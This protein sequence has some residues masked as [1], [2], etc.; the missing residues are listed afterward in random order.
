MKI[1]VMR[2]DLRDFDLTQ[3]LQVVG[4][5]RQYMCV[6]VREQSSVLGSIFVKAG[7]VLKVDAPGAQGREALFDLIAHSEGQF[8]VFRM[9]TPDILPEPIGALHGLLIEARNDNAK[10]APSQSQTHVSVPPDAGIPRSSTDS[11]PSNSRASSTNH[12]SHASAG[13]QGS[14]ASSMPSLF[15]LSRSPG[16][17]LAGKVISVAS[18]K[19]GCGKTTL[20]LNIALSLARQGRSVVLV[21]A[22]I[23]GDILSAIDA[24][25]RAQAGAFETL[26]GIAELDDALLNTVLPHFRILPAVGNTL[27]NASA[28]N[29]DHSSAWSALLRDLSAQAEIVVV[30]TPA[31]MFGVT[32]QVL[33][34]SS[35]VLGVLQA[36][37]L[38]N[39][40]FA[41]F[42]E[43]VD[44]IP[45][46]RRPTIV[47]I[48]I[49]MLQTSHSASLSVFQDACTALP[50]TL[51]FDTSIPRHNVFLDS[52]AVG[53]PIRLLDERAPPAIAW[54]F[55]NLAAEI[56]DRLH[57][58][59]VE[60]RPQPLLL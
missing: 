4:I 38:A 42:M 43:G 44:A 13:S 47:G 18:P 32:Q 1:G 52:T 27:P 60:R 37:V 40:S 26:L 39:R 46:L 55:D 20:A 15:S 28:L 16:E 21:D 17:C 56:V 48:A 12:E 6:E 45:M 2:G 11:E 3:V 25:K 5:G 8:H 53:V 29:A 34:A 57:L 31:G 33:Q 58:E 9:E 7:H 41:R 22:D 51:L 49:N 36:E 35:H 23:N 10:D 19:G 14:S 30:D 59:A 24:R 50:P 54:L